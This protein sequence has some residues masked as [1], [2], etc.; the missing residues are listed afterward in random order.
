MLADAEDGEVIEAGMEAVLLRQGGGEGGDEVV[1]ELLLVAAG[2]SDQ[3]V[4]A[5]GAEV[6]VLHLAE[7]EVG[8][9]DEA[10]V[11][12]PGEDAVDGGAADIGEAGGDERVDLVGGVVCA[13]GLE[14][15]EDEEALGGETLALGV[16]LLDD[17]RIGRGL[18]GHRAHPLSRE[19]SQARRV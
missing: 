18:V 2:K 5:M 11:L 15:L 16:E 19:Q 12:Q 13:G 3:E 4:V 14:G 9:A 17:S 1:R 6:L 7:A 10:L 8:D